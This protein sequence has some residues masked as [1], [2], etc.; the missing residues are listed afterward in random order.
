MQ[1]MS[2][3][4]LAVAAAMSGACLSDDI[5]SLASLD[6]AEGGGEPGSAG[7]G[8]PCPVT[9]CGTNSPVVD[10]VFFWRTHLGGLPN[11]EGISMGAVT[12]PDGRPMRLELVGG[13][14]LRGVDVV[15][16]ALMAEH[17]G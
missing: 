1:M 16:G 13:D 11:P 7:S 4:V 12:A 10:G 2:I 3:K 6:Q 14:R 5:D 9:G 8:N 17:A 15:T